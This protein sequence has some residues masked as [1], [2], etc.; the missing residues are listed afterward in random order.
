MLTPRDQ[1]R[2]T[3]AAPRDSAGTRGGLAQSAS[4]IH[5]ASAFPRRFLVPRNATADSSEASVQ[6]MAEE[7]LTREPR[8]VMAALLRHPGAFSPL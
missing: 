8:D 4:A 3:E 1:R 7:M 6:F 2:G 5:G